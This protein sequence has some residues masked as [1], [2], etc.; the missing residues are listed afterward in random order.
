MLH[1]LFDT[2]FLLDPN[3]GGW[4]GRGGRLAKVLKKSMFHD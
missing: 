3:K 4:K 1:H 2:H